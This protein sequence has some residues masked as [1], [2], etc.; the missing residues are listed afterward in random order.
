MRQLPSTSLVG[1]TD[2]A[3]GKHWELPSVLFSSALILVAILEL[4]YSPLQDVNL[5]VCVH[6]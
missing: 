5:C 3:Y 4:Q 2:L 1:E 6:A